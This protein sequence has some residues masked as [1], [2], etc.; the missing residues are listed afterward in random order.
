MDYYKQM[1]E[2]ET[3]RFLMSERRR[4]MADARR[5]YRGDHDVLR[6]VRTAVGADGGMI[7]L[8]RLPCSR[9]VNNQYGRLVDQKVNYS[10]GRP[11][12]VDCEDRIFSDF[13]RGYFNGGAQSLWRRAATDAINCGVSFLHPYIDER[14]ELAL[15]SFDPMWCVPLWRD[16]AHTELDALVRLCPVE[17]YEGRRAK[18][19]MLA[20]VYDR[21][22]V[23]EYE[24]RGGEFYE[25]GERMCHFCDADG[26]GYVWDRV[27]II[28]V[29][30][31]R[32]GIPMIR[33][34]RA[35]QDAINELY[36]DFC[37]NMKE[38]SR[39]SVLVLK[40]FDGEDLGEFRRN[41]AVY[42]AVKVRSEPGAEGGVETLSVD[43]DADN[44]DSICAML[45][46]ALVECCRGFDSHSDRLGSNPN[47]MNVLAMYSDIDLDANG[48]ECE[49]AGAFDEFVAYARS[50]AYYT[51]IGDFKRTNV[52]ISCSRDLLINEKNT[53]ESLSKSQG[54]VSPRT[55]VM[56]HPLVDD[57][58]AELERLGIK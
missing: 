33:R 27:P 44:Y 29:K 9:V 2:G 8:D 50:Y 28:A 45:S 56:A 32:D 1:L 55:L 5:Y 4:E 52:K 26:N 42:G 18:R 54:I 46:E 57:A 3:E 14:G 11:L 16:R 17:R 20:F 24:Y 21:H 31:N 23:A 43:V 38:N 6:R 22:G 34:A 35:L 12:V 48:F 37:D 41:L 25:R 13:L 40:N 53:I 30:Y 7:T 58:D 49:L 51:G 47:E 15:T 36:S 10:L 19:E 39:S